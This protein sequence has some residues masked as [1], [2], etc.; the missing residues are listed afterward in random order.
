MPVMR[1]F[2]LTYLP[3]IGTSAIVGEL[4]SIRSHCQY[5]IVRRIADGGMATV[6]EGAQHGAD[7]FVKKVAVKV[8]KKQYARQPLFL[9]NFIGEARLVADLIHTNIVQTY[10]LGMSDGTYFIAME[11]IR[12]MNLEQF[13]YMLRRHGLTLPVELA[14]FIAS[15][16]ARGL[17]YAHAKKTSE[18]EALGIVHRDISPKNILLAFEGDVKISDFG[19]AKAA[20]FLID[21]EGDVLAGKSEFM[22]PEQAD[23]KVTDRR[24]DLFATGIVLSLMLLGSNPFKGEDGFDSR[25]NIQTLATPDFCALNPNVDAELNRILHKCLCKDLDGRYQTADELL[26]DLERYIYR[27]G[28][29]PTNETLGKYL[30]KISEE[31]SPDDS[32]TGRTDTMIRNYRASG[33]GNQQSTA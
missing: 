9:E 18:G 23:F 24:S 19:I 11:L 5:N 30:R 31:F 21:E 15:R 2:V 12:G 26:G 33:P 32:Q 16:I 20:G 17:A 10:Q 28:F 3:F 8:I 27:D 29:G 4:F 14:V 6:Y 1:D 25:E 13:L 22:S 7:G